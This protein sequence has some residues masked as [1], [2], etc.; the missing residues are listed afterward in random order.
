MLALLA[1]KS[2]QRVVILMLAVITIPIAFIAMPQKWWERMQTITIENPDDS[3]QG[4]FNAWA[5]SWN[6]A[7][8]RP[9]VGGG[10]SVDQ[11]DVFARYA[12]NPLDVHSAHSNYF[13][14][15]GEHGFVGLALFLLIAFLMWRTGTQIIRTHR[16]SGTRWRADMARALQVS[17]IGFLVGGLT[18][19]IA[20][21]D[22][23]YF[24]IVLLVALQRLPQLEPAVTTTKASDPAVR[25]LSPSAE[26]STT[27]SA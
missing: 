12:P 27:S 3:I 20:Y 11:P 9:I 13:Q 15:L 19:N 21:W 16:R 8:D 2:R 24:E 1:L 23:Y 5:M 10:F 17:M 14:V 18:V 26:R 4:R 22:V 25:A 7:L 6:L